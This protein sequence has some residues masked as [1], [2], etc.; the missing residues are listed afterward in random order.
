MNARQPRLAGLASIMLA[1]AACGSTNPSSTASPQASA[2]STA[3]ASSAAPVETLAPV[4]PG[5]LLDGQTE[6]DWGRI[7]DSLP[8]GF[9]IYRGA[10]LSDEIGGGPTSGTYVVDGGVPDTIAAWYQGELEIAAFSTEAMSGPLEDGSWVI[11]SVGRDPGCRLRLTVAP[12]GG[13]TSLT[14]LY[15]AA[16]PH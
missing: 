2:S 8:T 11:D 7:W 5:P 15:G 14:F 16:C 13:L 4:T 1:V 10:T 3:S 12:L 9:P 6:T